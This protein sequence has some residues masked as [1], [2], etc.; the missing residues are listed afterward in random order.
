MGQLTAFLVGWGVEEDDGE[1][2]QIPHAEDPCEDST[3]D[4]E[5]VVAAVQVSIT[6][7]ERQHRS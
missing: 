6:N 7:L 5:G 3:V 1:N 4:L 2:I